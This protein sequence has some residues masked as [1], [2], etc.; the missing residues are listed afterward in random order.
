MNQTS[1]SLLRTG[2]A[3]L[4]CLSFSSCGDAP[5]LVRKREEQRAEIRML[6]GELKILQEKID[7][8]PPDRAT[9]LIKLKGESEQQKEDIARLEKE[10]ESL[11]AEKARIEKDHEAY[12]RKYVVR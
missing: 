12:K 7:Q 9:E 4:L 2:A 3:L 10:I 6:D 1:S 11:Q 5:E 8:L